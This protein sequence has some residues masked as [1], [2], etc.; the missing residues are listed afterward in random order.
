VAGLITS[1]V[2]KMTKTNKPLR[3]CQLEDITGSVE[4]VA[5]SETLEQFG[6]L[7]MDGQKVALTGKLQF[8]GDDGVSIIANSVRS[9]EDVKVLEVRFKQLPR[10]EEIAYLRE[11]LA[12]SKGSDPVVIVWGDHSRM[13]V[14]QQFWVNYE[15]AAVAL[16]NAMSNGL[17]HVLEPPRPMMISA[18]AS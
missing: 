12:K 13:Q 17:A 18:T 11:I 8:R 1:M 15:Q 10:Y 4:F 7:L 9:L 16:G 14:G 5:F 6:D 2:Q 3:I